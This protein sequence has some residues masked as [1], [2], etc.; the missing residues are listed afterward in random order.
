MWLRWVSSFRQ[1][2]KVKPVSLLPQVCA[3]RALP[4]TPGRGQPW[5]ESHQLWAGTWGVT[6]DVGTSDYHKLWRSLHGWCGSY[7]TH[8]GSSD[9]AEVSTEQPKGQTGWSVCSRVGLGGLTCSPSPQLWLHLYHI[10]HPIPCFGLIFLQFSGLLSLI[11]SGSGRFW[12][13]EFPPLFISLY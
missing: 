4:Q 6:F 7:Q 5:Q 10:Q 8:R 12:L 9:Q 2:W 11:L 3:S 13:L 1:S